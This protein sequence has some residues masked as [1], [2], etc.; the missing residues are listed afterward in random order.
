MSLLNIFKRQK[1]TEPKAQAVL[2][3]VLYATACGGF[4]ADTG[5]ALR[6]IISKSSPLDFEFL[7][8]GSFTVYFSGSGEGKNEA[9]ELANLL[10]QYARKNAIPS[11]GVAIQVGEC[12]VA[13]DFD[14]RFASR[15]S[16]LTINHAMTA[17]HKEASA[18]AL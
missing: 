8:P 1:D 15:P 4:S 10:R 11:F 12:I 16:G 6:D 14:G 7:S 9:E 17:A 5:N 13:F 3:A 2:L 18:N